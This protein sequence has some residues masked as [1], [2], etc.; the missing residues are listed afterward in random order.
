MSVAITD[1]RSIKSS[2]GFEIRNYAELADF[3]REMTTEDIVVAVYNSITEYYKQEAVHATTE[4]VE[5][6][7]ANYFGNDCYAVDFF[8]ERS[9]L[10]VFIDLVDSQS[11]SD[12]DKTITY[13][14]SELEVY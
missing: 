5:L 14:G 12:R 8:A 9:H 4:R 1:I 10:T 6:S 7:H 11:F 2:Y 13:L 3:P